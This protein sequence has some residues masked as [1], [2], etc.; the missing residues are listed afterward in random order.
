MPY[1]SDWMSFR[2]ACAHIASVEGC[3]SISALKQLRSACRDGKI[4]TDRQWKTGEQLKVL[5]RDVLKIWSGPTGHPQPPRNT[6]GGGQVHKRELR[7]AIKSA[8]AQHGYPGRTV[9]W[10]RFCDLVR[11]ECSVTAATR[12]YGDKTIKRTVQAIAA[13]ERDK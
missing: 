13:E 2:Q 10:Q 4:R 3:D 6:R 9:Q 7:R 12:G 1:V 8:I 5:R 11:A